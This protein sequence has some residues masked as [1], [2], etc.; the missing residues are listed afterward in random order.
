MRGRRWGCVTATD[1]T[2]FQAPFRAGIRLDAYQLE[3]L[4][5]ALVLP[6]V[7]LLIA[8]DVGLG[9]TIEA[10]LIL[11]ELLLRRRIDFVVV[12]APPSMLGQW[13][14]ELET[15]FGLRFTIIDRAFVAAMRRERGFS[16]NPWLTA[17]RFLISHRLLID[18]TYSSGLLDTLHDFRPGSLLILDEAHH[19]APAGGRKYAIDSQITKAIRDIAPKFEHRLFLTATPHNGHPNSFSALM[20]ILDPQR[21]LR[22]QPIEPTQLEPVMVRRLKEDLRRLGQTFPERIIEPIIIG[23]LPEH[24]PELVLAAKLAE[25][26]DIRRKRLAVETASRRAQAE[27]VW[28]SLQQR[29]LSSIEAFARTLRVHEAALRRVLESGPPPRQRIN[30]RVVTLLSGIGADDDAAILGD[31]DLRA[32]E[33]GAIE[34]ATLASVA[35]AGDRWQAQVEAEL[36]FVM[37]MRGLADAS[38]SA[39]D[40][41]M[42]RLIDWIDREMVPGLR[43]GGTAWTGRRLLIFTEYEDTRRWV[44][45]LLRE[46]LAHTERADERIAI[47]SGSTPE[48]RNETNPGKSREEIKLAF[49]S[50]PAD[51]PLRILIATDAAREGLNLQRHC[52]D[53]FHLDLPWNPSR[54]EQRNGRIDRKLQ[55]AERVYCR[56][57]TYAQRPEDRVLRRLVEKTEVIRKQLGSASPVIETR[58]SELLAGGIDRNRADLV[59]TEIDRIEQ[60]DKEQRARDDLEP[61]R[62]ANTALARKIEQLRSQLQRSRRRVGVDQVQLQRV[63]TYGLK[64]AGAPPL[65]Q[66]EANGGPKRFQFRADEIAGLRDDGLSRMLAALRNSTDRLGT[67]PLRPVSFD[68]PQD[69]DAE[70]V[71]LHLEH[72]LVTR[73]IDRFSNQGLVHHELSRACLAVAPDAIPRIVLMGRLSLWG[74]GA[75]R[76]HEEIVRVAARWVEPEIRKAKLQPY[77]REAER[78]TMD[79]LD[80]TLD[81][82]RRFEVPDGIRDRLLAGL[83][84]DVADLLPELERRADVVAE[85]AR[86]QLRER[87]RTEAAS[88][89]ALIE[90]QRRRIERDLDRLDDPQ[91]RLDLDTAEERRQRE[92]DIRAWQA[93]LTKIGGE[94]D[95]QP[96][97]ILAGYEVRAQRLEPVGVVY[98]WPATG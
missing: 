86:D 41:R 38:R 28:I 80:R 29:L 40:A 82:P 79:S 64:L 54:L 69:A 72:P 11:R 97:R 59:A 35:G 47:F 66:E 10:G 30:K 92:L 36:D 26:R 4:R 65:H 91:L 14:D 42:D 48:K 90:T 31:E 76:L 96:A 20:E 61:V 27:L 57:F 87:G 3:P 1:P 62:E 46:A 6:R 53:L 24:A 44:E 8:D 39:L 25:Y 71:Q 77:S 89:R 55:P 23:G 60:S 58:I 33:D 98:L 68:P 78:Q 37:D 83:S 95:E 45:R 18:P 22:G 43:A 85:T 15:R 49:N 70:T 73:L 7:N 56:Y 50:P 93:R 12:A 16:V 2:L 5:K 17:S 63:V 84:R 51:H 67:G 75:A 13:A 19:A 52:R 9:K 21:F 34:T 88:L 32:E 74:T 94:I 81:E